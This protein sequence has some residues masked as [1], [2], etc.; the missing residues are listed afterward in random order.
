MTRKPA[1]NASPHAMRDQANHA[2]GFVDSARMERT[3]TVKW[4]DDAAKSIPQFLE[5][6]VAFSRAKWIRHSAYLAFPLGE[7]ET[8]ARSHASSRSNCILR[9]AYHA[10]G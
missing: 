8:A 2:A 10:A 3:R 4:S 6:W 9:T 5:S 7:S 1:S